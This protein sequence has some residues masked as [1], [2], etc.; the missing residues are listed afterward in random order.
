[1]RGRWPDAVDH[2]FQTGVVSIVFA[3]DQRYFR[4]SCRIVLYRSRNMFEL[5]SGICLASN[6]SIDRYLNL[7]AISHSRPKNHCSGEDQF[8]KNS[9][10]TNLISQRKNYTC[11]QKWKTTP[12]T[13][14]YFSGD[15][16]T[17]PPFIT[18]RTFRSAVISCVGSP[19]TAIRSANR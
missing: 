7:S 13:T 4:V 16:Y 11:E 1:M 6:V 5:E 2:S 14:T 18:N 8:A 12:N 19:S 17:M 3:H 10:Q 15:L 9:N